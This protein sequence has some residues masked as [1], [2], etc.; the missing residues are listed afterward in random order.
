MC[1]IGTVLIDYWRPAQLG[2]TLDRS[3]AIQQSLQLSISFYLELDEHD[4]DQAQGR[5]YGVLDV[6]LGHASH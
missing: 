2:S 5:E 3:Y 1:R 4:P 6:P